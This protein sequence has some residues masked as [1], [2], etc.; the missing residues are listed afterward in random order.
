MTLD[1]QYKQYKIQNPESLLN[2]EE[3]KNQIYAP[4]ILD[5]IKQVTESMSKGI[6]E[7]N[8]LIS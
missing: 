3:W 2:F 5:A 8:K 4:S 1:S 7:I 6:D